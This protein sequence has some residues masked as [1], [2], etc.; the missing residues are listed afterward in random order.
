MIELVFVVLFEKENQEK[1]HMNVDL[2][3]FL[4]L[5]DREEKHSNGC[6]RV[7]EGLNDEGTV[8]KGRKTQQPKS[9]KKLEGCANRNLCL[10]QKHA[11]T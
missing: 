3:H 9:E 5:R 4:C 11:W 10:L 7:L 2:P 8:H 6:A 1:T